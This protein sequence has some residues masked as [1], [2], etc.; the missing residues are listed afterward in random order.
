MLGLSAMLY[1]GSSLAANDNLKLGRM[2]DWLVPEGDGPVRG[3][4]QHLL[5]AD[6]K[7]FGLLEVRKFVAA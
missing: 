2:T 4:G 5:V 1:P 3:V 6:D 7:D